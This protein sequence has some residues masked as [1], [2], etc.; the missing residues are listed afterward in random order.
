MHCPNESRGTKDAEGVESESC[1]GGTSGRACVDE[2]ETIVECRQQLG[3]ADGD[4]DHRVEPMGM[5]NESDA[6][7]I[8][9]IESESPDGGGIPRVHLGDT[10]SCSGNANGSGNWMEGST[11]Q[12]D[13]SRGQTDNSNTSN[14]A[15]MA[16]IRDGEGAGTYLGVGGVKHVIDPTNGVGSQSDASSGH[17]DVPS[18]QTDAISTANATEIVSIPPKRKKPPDLPSRGTNQPPDESNG[19]GDH[20]D[21]SSGCTHA[22]CVGNDAKT[23]ANTPE[24]V[25]IP[26]NEQKLLNSPIGTTR[27]TPDEPNGCGSHADALIV[28][29]DGRVLR[30]KQER[31]GWKRI[32]TRQNALNQV[33]DTKLT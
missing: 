29:T 3:M 1:K 15:G 33:E 12:V 28:R 19:L 32:G 4:R 6:L 27:W 26:R 13:V 8:V 22:S 31:N 16:W 21:A 14:R 5:P 17:S 9:S 7:V 18:V 25:S 10:R 11:G 2:L 30:W 24:D 20:T 23:A